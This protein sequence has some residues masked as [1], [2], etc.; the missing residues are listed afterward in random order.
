MRE[1]SPIK[2]IVVLL[3]RETVE[4]FL[5]IATTIKNAKTLNP[6][7]FVQLIY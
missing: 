1:A 4:G 2:K 3:H 7:L 5:M 6:P